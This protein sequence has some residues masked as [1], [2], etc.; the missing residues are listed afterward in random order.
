MFL[1][2]FGCK[3]N[4][5]VL[6]E[7]NPTADSQRLENSTTC[8]LSVIGQD[9]VRISLTDSGGKISR[10]IDFRNSETDGSVGAF[11]GI[12][13]GDTIKLKA[14]TIAEGYISHNDIY[15]LEKDGKL[16]EG[17]GEIK[18]QNDSTTVF[19]DPAKIDYSKSFVFSK[20][21]CPK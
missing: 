21:D 16:Y 18:K 14:R 20:T 4:S 15:L 7:K 2:V 13:S 10:E 9:S 17:V 5:E 8:Y 1:I 11:I 12:K 6:S 3:K 19:A